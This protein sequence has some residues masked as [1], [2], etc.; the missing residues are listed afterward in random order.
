MTGKGTHLGLVGHQTLS[1]GIDLLSPG[2]SVRLLP[3]FV[4]TSLSVSCHVVSCL[5]PI[6]PLIFILIL[7]ARTAPAPASYQTKTKPPMRQPE[8]LHQPLA[9][10]IL[11]ASIR[12]MELRELL[13][14]RPPP[15]LVRTYLIPFGPVDV[16]RGRREPEPI[17]DND[18][19]NDNNN[20]DNGQQ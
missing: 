18:N 19:D 2:R 11:V 12:G 9:R 10:S 16:T 3:M 14:S 6:F 20:N 17:G 4:H 7:L 1:N 13:P 8:L 15:R 5:V